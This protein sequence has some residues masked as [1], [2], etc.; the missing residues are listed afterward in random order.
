MHV[1][2]SSVRSMPICDDDMQMIV[3]FLHSPLVDADTGRIQG[4]FVT[5]PAFG[6]QMQFLPVMDITAWGTKVHIRTADVLSPP[7]ELIRLQKYFDDPRP[8]MGQLIRIRESGR[9]LG[10]CS[11]IQFDTRHFII[12][13]LFPRGLLFYRQPV[14]AREISEVT[15]DAIWIDDP[16]R[17]VK[18]KVM[19]EPVKTETV[20]TL[21]DISP[22]QNRIKKQES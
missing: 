14:A 8:F 15:A 4:F 2:W 5:A 7:E 21:P 13:W 11:D 19:E 18:D 3:A 17:R 10:R 12:E 1:R 20:I 6:S 9:K 22:A 16:L